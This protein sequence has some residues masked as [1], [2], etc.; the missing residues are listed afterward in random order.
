MGEPDG[1]AEIAGEL[2][3]MMPNYFGPQRFGERQNNQEVGKGDSKGDFEGAVMEFLT[4][5][6]NERNAKVTEARIS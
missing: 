5:T 6:E 4:S 1:T 2:G 3:G